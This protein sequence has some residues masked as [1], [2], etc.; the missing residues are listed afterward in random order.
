MSQIVNTKQ[1]LLDAQKGKY[2]VPAF[3]IHNMET[4]QAVIETAV[5]MRS[6]VILAAT[7]GTMDYAG[8][9]Y[10]QAIV[11]VAAKENDIPIALHLDHHET[12]DSIQTSLEL[13]TKSVMIDG[14]H[15]SFEENIALTK[16]VVE[17]A[18]KHGATVEAELGKLVGQEDD[19]VVTEQE[20]AYTDPDTVEEF[21]ERTGVD[22][23]A[24]AIGTGHGVYEVEPQ[25]DFDRLEKIAQLVDVPIVLH[26]ASG[27]SKADVQKCIELGCCKVNISTELKI[28]FSTA[29]RDFLVAHPEATDPRKYMTPAKEEMKKTVREKISICKSDGKA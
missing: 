27:I 28:P 3:N 25:L 13:G 1:M 9:A 11:E 23:L 7:P 10:I 5:E 16:Q 8:R 24:V 14:S 22:S 2:A 19:L 17:L 4:V 26:G 18:Q 20:A 15:H 29:L 6:P 12:V 21:V